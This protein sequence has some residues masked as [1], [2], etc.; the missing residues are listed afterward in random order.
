MGKMVGVI[1]TSEQPEFDASVGK[2]V[3]LPAGRTACLHC[4]VYS[5]GNKTVS[6]FDAEGAQIV[7]ELSCTNWLGVQ[8]GLSLKAKTKIISV[9]FFIEVK[10]KKKEKPELDSSIHADMLD[11]DR[12]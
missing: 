5:L 7:G 6:F 4:R 2:N 1:T 9:H 8:W 11:G 12:R 10:V 3:S